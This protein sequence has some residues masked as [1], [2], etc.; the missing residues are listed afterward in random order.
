MTKKTEGNK[1]LASVVSSFMPYIEQKISG[2][3][4]PGLDRD[5]LRQEAF[6]ALFSAIESYDSSKGALFSTYAITCINNRLADAVRK[7]SSG[8]NRVLNES[9]PLSDEEDQVSV[10]SE[11]SPE[12]TAI[13]REE[14]M[15]ILEKM[16]TILSDFE[17]EVLVMYSCGYKYAEIAERK[18]TTAKAVSNAIQRARKKLRQE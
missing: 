8:K 14:Y 2:L 3:S 17:R 13:V 1:R 10:I 18:N 15:Q 7:A 16:D 9:V 12:E 6:V 5:D 11:E 4:L